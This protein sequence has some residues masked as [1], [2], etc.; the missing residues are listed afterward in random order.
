M[1]CSPSADPVAPVRCLCVCRP[2]ECLPHRLPRSQAA[3]HT[4]PPTTPRGAPP[5]PSYSLS[6]I[7]WVFCTPLCFA[8][9]IT[10]RV[11]VCVVRAFLDTRS[12]YA[13]VKPA[14]PGLGRF[15]RCR[16]TPSL[17]SVVLK[18]T[19]DVGCGGS[20]WLFV[21]GVCCCSGGQV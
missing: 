15:R 9:W 4:L 6:R 1:R 13:Q 3:H 17:R 10:L 16:L 2:A 20:S 5:P 21:T 14:T 18:A 12:T 19:V 7:F 8:L 11:S